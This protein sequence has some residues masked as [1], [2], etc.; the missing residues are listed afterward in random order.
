MGLL[1]R[2]CG[3]NCLGC[4]MV[5]LVALVVLAVVVHL[6]STAPDYPPVAPASLAALRLP[7]LQATAELSNGSEIALV[8]LTDAQ[9]TALL[10]DS[11]GDYDGLSDPQVNALQGRVVV[12][13]RTSI[14][15]HSLVVSGPVTFK[16][17]GSSTIDLEF[18]GLS[19]GEMPLP[20]IVPQLISRN[21]HPALDLG[22]VGAGIPV[23]FA[24]EASRPDRLTVGIAVG[25]PGKVAAAAACGPS[26]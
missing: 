11:L 1:R 18:S 6:L 16:G 20:T 9:A 3:L 13:G 21:F 10:R 17:V 26:S 15:G 7:V 12:S 22:V 5:A 25:R 19:I 2:G 24:C 23:T 8:H 4:S 14:L